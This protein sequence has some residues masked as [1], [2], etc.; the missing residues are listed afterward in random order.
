MRSY[1]FDKL[2]VRLHIALWAIE[3]LFEKGKEDRNH[4]D[5]FQGLSKDDEEDGDSKDLGRHTV[6]LRL[7]MGVMDVGC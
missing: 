7:E 3:S 5:R 6:V 2:L 4:D 1:L